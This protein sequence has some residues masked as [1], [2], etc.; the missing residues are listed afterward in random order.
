[1]SGQLPHT[2]EMGLMV[3][4]ETCIDAR[5]IPQYAS[6]HQP[7]GGTKRQHLIKLS[8][9]RYIEPPGSW[10]NSNELFARHMKPRR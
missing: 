8:L 4:L 1:M 6:S 3:T 9:G 10:K 7:R 2:L 5:E